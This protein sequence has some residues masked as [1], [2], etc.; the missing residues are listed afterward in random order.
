M[1]AGAR[2]EPDLRRAPSPIELRFPR[3][4]AA[5]LAARIRGLESLDLAAIGRELRASVVRDHSVE[6]WAAQI[7]ELAAR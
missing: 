7:V 6:S 1:P 2:L 3:E 4:D 5:A